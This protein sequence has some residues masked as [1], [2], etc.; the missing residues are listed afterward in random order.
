MV[1]NN[2][3]SIVYGNKG[4]GRAT[5]IRKYI[6]NTNAVVFPFE[7]QRRL[8]MIREDSSR[9]RRRR[10]FSTWWKRAAKFFEDRRGTSSRT[11][12]RTMQYS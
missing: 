4:E 5:S 3:L 2:E 1:V 8:T 7:S 11:G 10:G 6:R 12:S 9:S